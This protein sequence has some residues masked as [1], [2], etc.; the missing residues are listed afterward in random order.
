MNDEL[1]GLEDSIRSLKINLES[2]NS[3][4]DLTVFARQLNDYLIKKLMSEINM[5]QQNIKIN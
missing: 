4:S 2:A 3:Q 5:I 1:S